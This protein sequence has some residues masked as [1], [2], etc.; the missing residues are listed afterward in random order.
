MGDL[1]IEYYEGNKLNYLPCSI[2]TSGEL[3]NLFVNVTNKRLDLW[4]KIIPRFVY[5]REAPF[6][7]ITVPTTDTVRMGYIM[8]K[9]LSVKYPV[10]FTGL[11]G[12][13]F[14]FSLPF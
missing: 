11:T 1:I 7:N 9:L 3:W 4:D 12:I 14:S 2:P 8:E 6:F 13:Q 5:D 10:L